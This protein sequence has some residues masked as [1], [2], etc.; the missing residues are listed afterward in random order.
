MDLSR[1]HLCRSRRKYSG[2]AAPLIMPRSARIAAE[3][4]VVLEPGVLAP[5]FLEL[6]LVGEI[7]R[8]AHAMQH[9]ALPDG[10]RP[11]VLPDHG[12]TGGNTGPC[13]TEDGDA[14]VFRVE[15]E[16]AHRRLSQQHVVESRV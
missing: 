8:V 14:W 2:D 1:G 15:A 6:I 10:G 3:E 11:G 5:V 13:K 7:G 4:H 9:D 12:H 16:G